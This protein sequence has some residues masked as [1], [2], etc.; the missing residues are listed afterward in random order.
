MFL[1]VFIIINFFL[2]ITYHSKK[3]NKF[4]LLGILVVLF[5]EPAFQKLTDPTMFGD[6]YMVYG[7]DRL[8]TNIIMG[9]TFIFL[10]MYP[11]NKSH[12]SNHFIFFFTIIM[13][14]LLNV[15]FSIDVQNSAALFIVSVIIPILLYLT[16][17]SLGENFFGN[18][19]N[20]L[21]SIYLGIITF[22]S[23]GLVMYNKTSSGGADVEE[24]FN[25]TGGG[26]WLSNVSTQVLALFFPLLLIKNPVKKLNIFRIIALILFFVLLTVSLSRTALFVYAFMM[27]FFL[28]KAKNK[29]LLVT[30]G[31]LFLVVSYYVLSAKL[32]FDL[33]EM[34]ET[35]F[36]G[37]GSVAETI[38]GDGRISI[39]GEALEVFKNSNI[40]LGNGISSFNHINKMGFSNAHNI[41]INILVERGLIGIAFLVGMLV[42]IFRKIG[43]LKRTFNLSEI[44]KRILNSLRLGLIGFFLIGMTGNDLFINSGFVNSWPISCIVVLICIVENKALIYKKNKKLLH[45]HLN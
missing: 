37:K 14:H 1:L 41:Y 42:Y 35:R 34:Y 10:L 44:D 12:L 45:D 15:I 5:M 36:H 13:F 17:M 28:L 7:I 31:M 21:F 27:L 26:L 3:L 6:S 9:A 8:K 25:R 20:V 18:N 16:L 33:I 38:E 4:Y 43:R 23:I 24:G 30:G 39:Y 40:F 32:N 29:M 22:I 11:K 2:V 19:S